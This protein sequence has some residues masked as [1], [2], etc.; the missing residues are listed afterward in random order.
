MDKKMNIKNIPKI[1]QEI[2]KAIKISGGNAI[3]VGGSIRD[4]LL[5]LQVKDYDIEVFGITDLLQLKNILSKFGKISET[6]KSFA[7]LKLFINGI[8][9]DFSLP[10]TE[11]KIGIGHKGFLVKIAPNISFKQAAARRDFTINSM[12]YDLNNAILL[13]PYYGQK[14]LSEKILRH[15]GP[16]FKEDPLRVLRA[17]QFASRFELD[18]HPETITICNELNISELPKERIFDEFKKLL[19][20]AKKPSYGFAYMTKLGIL[21]HFPELQ[22]LIGVNQDPKWHPEGDVWQHTLLVVDEMAKLRTGKEKKDLILMFAAL[23]HDFGKAK[24]TKFIDGRWRS[25]GHEKAGIVPTKSFLAKLTDEKNLIE[26]IIVLVKHHLKPVLLY[27]SSLNNKV[28]NAAILRL[29]LKAP[30]NDLLILAKA[31]HFGR[32]SKEALLREFP[33]GKWLLE[34]AE[35]LQ[36]KDDKPKPFLQGRHLL[37]LGINPGPKIGEILKQVFE[38]QIE[39]KINSIEDAINFLNKNY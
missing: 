5:G 28:S 6:G 21:K 18:I 31:D 20:K 37:E 1:V 34:R 7:V 10:R 11:S 27:N 38:L 36:V 14:D 23:C 39:G 33:A 16:A 24:T 3:L 2:A 15:I 12:G 25:L 17:A 19:L 26:A 22:A 32:A 9:L 13:D 4:I 8:E 30:I 35:Q 29:A